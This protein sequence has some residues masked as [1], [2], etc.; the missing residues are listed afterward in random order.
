MSERKSDNEWA[1]EWMGAQYNQSLMKIPGRIW[2]MATD[3]QPDTNPNYFKLVLDKFAE[4]AMPLEAAGTMPYIGI[5]T[6]AYQAWSRP[7]AALKKI[8][9]AVKAGP[10]PSN[11]QDLS[12][13]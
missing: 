11:N 13:N 9:D 7:D 6:F 5:N 3:W 12:Y 8:R 10:Q 4:W 1:A 2:F